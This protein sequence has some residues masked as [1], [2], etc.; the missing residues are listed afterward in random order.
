MGLA[1]L[2]ELTGPLTVEGWP[3]PITADNVVD[4]TL[5]EAYVVYDQEKADRIDFLATVAS[6]SVDALR[7]ADLGNPARVA[8]TLG[9]AARGGHLNLWFTRPTEQALVDRLGIAGR[10]DPVESDS[11][12]VVNQNGG[13]NKT[14]YYFSRT[15]A[16]DTQL[17][18]EGDRLAVS[19][20]LRIDMENRSPG[21]GLPRYIIGPYDDRFQA[22]EN[23][24]FVSV[25]SPWP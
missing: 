13:A 9:A 23:R 1:A 21:E 14:D 10:V 22:G 19:S 18:P 25:Y 15:T 12:L 7:T 8:G 24:S 3:V 17:R 5:N 16:Y 11:L 20:R 2:L 6:A 4:V